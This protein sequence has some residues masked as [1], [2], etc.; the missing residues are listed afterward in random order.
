LSTTTSPEQKE[1]SQATTTTTT[2]KTRTY[3]EIRDEIA[4]KG[5]YEFEYADGPRAG[6]KVRMVRKKI[7]VAKMNELEE[8]RAEYGGLI[9]EMNQ[10]E[11]S[12]GKVKKRG[13]VYE[14]R[15]KAAR[16]LTDIYA[17]CAE[18]YFHI[19][20]EDFE[21]LDWDTTKIN[22][23]ASTNVSIFGRPNLA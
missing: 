12:D 8:M 23:D 2:D 7:S 4:K 19:K 16:L 3:E 20:R 9:T 5:I 11:D 22:L 15:K 6:E 13:L 14:D 18:Y 1:E 10:L 21:M 17:K